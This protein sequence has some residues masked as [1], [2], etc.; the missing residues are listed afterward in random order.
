LFSYLAQPLLYA[1]SH[2]QNGPG[3]KRLDNSINQLVSLKYA[4][5]S[6]AECNSAVHK[7]KD[8]LQRWRGEKKVFQ[9]G[10]LLTG[11]HQEFTRTSI[12]LIKHFMSL[13]THSCAL[14]HIRALKKISEPCNITKK[15]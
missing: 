13:G 10:I 9:E 3:G 14:L 5:H 12:L 8:N 15:R 11:S 2:Y 7:M 6:C 4:H 1:R